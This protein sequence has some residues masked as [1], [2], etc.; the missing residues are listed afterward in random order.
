MRGPERAGRA[1][2]GGLVLIRACTRPERAGRAEDRL[3][4]PVL[5]VFSAGARDVRGERIFPHDAPCRNV[6]RAGGFPV[7]S[8]DIPSFRNALC[9][10]EGFR[11]TIFAS[12]SPCSCAAGEALPG[13]YGPGI[14]EA[15]ASFLNMCRK[16]VFRSGVIFSGRI[17]EALVPRATAEGRP[18]LQKENRCRGVALFFPSFSTNKKCG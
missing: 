10:G 17:T 12:S 5:E 2:C 4:F 3:R 14:P 16:D 15:S 18:A 11:Q 1:A 6:R 7:F 13:R 8:P 9:L